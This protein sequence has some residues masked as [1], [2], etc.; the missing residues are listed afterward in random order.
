MTIHQMPPQAWRDRL[1]VNSQG[2]IVNNLF[3]ALVAVR[4]FAHVS[5]RIY[6]DELRCEV[7]VEGPLP[8]S[9]DID[10]PWSEDDDI[11]LTAA[12]QGLS[13]LQITSTL[14]MVQ[15]A[16]GVVAKDRRR[17]P[18]R[19]WLVGLQWDG[20][21]RIG[22]WL[23][24]YLGTERTPYVQAVGRAWLISA[25]ARIMQPGCKA[26]NILILDGEQGV[27]KSTALRILV[28]DRYF[29]DELSEP[30][31]RDAAVQM[32]GVWV[33]EVAELAAFGTAAIER[34][35]AFVTRTTD[36]IV[37]KY[38]RRTKELP[39]QCVFAG[40]SN[41]TSFRDHTGNRRFWPVNVVHLDRDALIAAR[42]QIWAEAVAA[43]RAGE[44]WWLVD[45]EAIRAAR[46]EQQ[47]RMQVD[48]WEDLIDAWLQHHDDVSV[49][50]ILADC[51]KIPTDRWTRAEEM[52][53]SKTLKI[54]GFIRYRRRYGNAL[55]WRYK[56]ATDRFPT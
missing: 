43:Y 31:S 39:R 17:H 4:G 8:W 28:G 35:K 44:P 42:E 41:E 48:P 37:P 33:I 52:R 10:R 11:L 29:T 46:D 36:R 30:G 6:W 19:E 32:C 53:V 20:T 51:I 45:E 50:Q 9:D 49:A 26:D 13:G 12:L 1:Q 16:V 56:R 18:L 21:E 24:Y 54:R 38:E 34:L 55:T 7:M 47:A 22:D 15:R 27:G 5:S 14:E 3:N 25:V 40:T 2:R 23:T